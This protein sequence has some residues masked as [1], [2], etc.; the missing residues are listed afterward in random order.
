[1]SSALN[2]PIVKMIANARSKL[3]TVTL[4]ISF[5]LCIMIINNYNQCKK[6]P[7]DNSAV[8]ASYGIAI[9]V[10]IISC[11]IFSFDLWTFYK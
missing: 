8:K 2:N 4:V 9:V 6:Y 11:L 7:A 10:L 5:V 1:M 3:N